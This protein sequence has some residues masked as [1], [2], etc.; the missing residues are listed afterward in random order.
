MRVRF[1]QHLLYLFGIYI[2]TSGCAASIRLPRH[3]EVEETRE[4]AHRMRKAIARVEAFMAE[5]RLTYFG[6]Q[7]RI[8]ATAEVAVK[9]PVAFRFDIVGPHGAVVEALS[10]DGDEIFLISNEK[11]VFQRAP[12]TAPYFDRLQTLLPLGLDAGGWVGLLLG[13]LPVPENASHDY[14]DE[15]GRFVLVYEKNAMSVRLHIDP[16]TY[17]ADRLEL[18]Q[19]KKRHGLVKISERDPLGVPTRLD[20]ESERQDVS[21]QIRIRDIEHRPI[22]S[23]TGAFQLRLPE[24]TQWEYLK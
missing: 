15:F 2:L 19:G 16:V 12:A 24:G 8:R 18:S 17:L 4:L 20:I 10:T 9:P 5:A 6:P 13:Y 21:L 23:T 11:S 22:R 3:L 7:G 1:R 14:N